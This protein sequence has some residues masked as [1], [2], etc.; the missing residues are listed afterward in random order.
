MKLDAA[1][2][3]IASIALGISVDN[4]IHIFYRFKN[5]L[6]VD[7]DYS[8]AVCRTLQGAGKTALFTS[9]SAAFGFMVFSFS[10]FKPVQYFGVLTSVTMIN[11][12]VSDLFISP[13]CLLLFKPRF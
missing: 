6:S 9:L 4:T 8:K 7:G 11:A 5:E 12:I 3:M 13:C 10:S 1:T 2:I